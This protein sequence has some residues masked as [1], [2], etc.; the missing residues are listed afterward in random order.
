MGETAHVSRG[1]DAKYRI[2]QGLLRKL[3]RVIVAYSGGTDSSFL[4][5]VALDAVPERV[6]AATARSPVHPAW[7]LGQVANTAREFGIELVVVD[8]EEL[9]LESFVANAPDRCYHCKKEIFAK[10]AQ[11]A[12]RKDITG[13]IDGSNADDCKQWRPGRR[14]AL[15]W[16]VRSPL[17]EAGLAKDEIR[18]LSSRLGL[19]TWDKPSFSCLASSFP[20][21][22]R[23]TAAE[24]QRVESA[25]A[26]MRQLGMRQV[27]V[28]VHGNLARVEVTEDDISRFAGR[29]LRRRVVSKFREL[30]YR[31]ISLDL[32]GYRSGSF[33]VDLEEGLRGD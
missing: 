25:D 2:L 6:I 23:I 14:A 30:G 4:L 3:R 22:Q 19:S 1:L 28:R 10:L 20:Y 16:G 17:A 15:E 21:G 5:R 7:E 12:R 33:D 26:F 13:L 24:L 27:R 11:L 32:E 9:A 29:S 31:Y 18:M 8:T